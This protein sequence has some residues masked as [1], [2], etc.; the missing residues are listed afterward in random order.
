MNIKIEKNKQ[1]SVILSD[2]AITTENTNMNADRIKL[3][4]KQFTLQVELDK[5]QEQLDL[6]NQ[7]EHQK[8]TNLWG[9]LWEE[10]LKESLEEH[11]DDELSDSYESDTPEITCNFRKRKH[12]T[13]RVTSSKKI[14]KQGRSGKKTCRSRSHLH[15]ERDYGFEV[16]S[17]SVDLWQ[18]VLVEIEQ[19]KEDYDYSYT[20]E[21][22]W[23]L[24]CM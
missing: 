9:L 24:Y 16:V 13:H 21:W 17:A 11:E 6:L 2:M 23:D 12:K 8:E 18:K 4:F 1:S 3:L 20:P 14:A 15:Q 19:V 5:V 22:Q 10:P 7:K